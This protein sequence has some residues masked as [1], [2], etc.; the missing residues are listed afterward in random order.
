MKALNTD[1]IFLRNLTI[2]LLDLLNSS[3]SIKQAKNDTVETFNVPFLYNYGVDSGFLSD[4]YIGLPDDCQIPTAEGTYDIIPRGIVTL[5]SFQIKSSDL[6]NR[7]IRGS[8]TEP[9]KGAQG[10]NVLTGYSAQLYSL[11]MSVKFDVKIIC[12]T[13][14]KAFKIAE[15]MLDVNYANRV[16]YFQYNG[17]RIPAQFQFPTTESATDGK[18]YTFTQADSNRMNVSL[19]IDVETYFPSFEQSSLRKSTNVMERINFRAKDAGG[20]TSI[21]EWIDQNTPA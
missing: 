16:M 8:F 21:D 1:D 15:R 4:F 17:V 13:L 9:E 7:F 3:I 10:E 20:I 12:D 18:K 2:A 11:P 5:N 6:T 19:S 14:N